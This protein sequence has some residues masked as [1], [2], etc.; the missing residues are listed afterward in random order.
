MQAAGDVI[1]LHPVEFSPFCPF[2]SSPPP[3]L[4]TPPSPTIYFPVKTY[5]VT[6]SATKIAA[7]S[8]IET[9]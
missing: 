8:L 4:P 1:T 7:I 3:L 5:L 2:H 9:G 6:C